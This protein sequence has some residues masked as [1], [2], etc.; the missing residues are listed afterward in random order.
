MRVA[1]G[2]KLVDERPS[3]AQLDDMA[4]VHRA[5]KPCRAIPG[6]Q[7]MWLHGHH[8]TGGARRHRHARPV[9][10]AR[11]SLHALAWPQWLVDGRG[12]RAPVLAVVLPSEAQEHHDVGVTAAREQP[13]L[14]LET[15]AHRGLDDLDRDLCAL[16]QGALVDAAAGP[17]TQ[18]ALLGE[19][20][21]GH[22]HL[23]PRILQSQVPQLWLHRGLGFP[24]PA[25]AASPAPQPGPGRGVPV[26]RL[27]GALEGLREGGPSLL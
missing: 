11:D 21:R 3:L 7:G 10:E 27:H 8:G 25:R 6:Y 24:R 14:L 4:P 13:H 15:A 2:E 23:R 22:G 17:G 26:A 19:A 16:L 12:R 9:A 5:C 20:A 1:T 18:A